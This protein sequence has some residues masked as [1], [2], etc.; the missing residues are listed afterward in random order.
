MCDSTQSTAGRE[1]QDPVARRGA[2]GEIATALWSEEVDLF[3]QT[4]LSKRR[5]D[6][7]VDGECVRSEVHA[8]RLRWYFHYEFLMMLERAGLDDTTTYS[9]Y[10]DHPATQESRAI[11]YGARCSGT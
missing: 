6:L 1:G 10:T 9:D 3:E 4:L 7:H 11:I 2:E 8:H 5:Y